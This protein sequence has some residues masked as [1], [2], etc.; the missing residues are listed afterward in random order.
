[1][2]EALARIGQSLEWTEFSG[3]DLSQS[4]A[5]D[6][7]AEA[8]GDVILARRDAPT[9]YHLSVVVDD[10]LQGVT[11]I[12]RGLDLF[13]ATAVHR[14]LQ[15]LLGL[16]RPAYHHHSLILGPDGRKLS[17]SFRDTG[18]A[19]LRNQ[20]ETPET[21]RARVSLGYSF[22]RSACLC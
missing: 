20:G 1:M 6:A 7:R 8:W 9:S 4:L 2:A 13:D 21:I 3:D 15:E 18:I 17:K 12:V 5:V 16:P 11:H 14:I 22:G 10:A 19:V